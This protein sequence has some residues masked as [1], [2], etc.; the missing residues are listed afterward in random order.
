M[1]RQG[2]RLA[3]RWD[4]RSRS[5]WDDR[6]RSRW[7]APLCSVPEKCV[8]VPVIG[9]SLAARRAPFLWGRWG[10]SELRDFASRSPLGFGA[11]GRV[12]RRRC[13]TLPLAQCAERREADV[14]LCCVCRSGAKQDPV[15]PCSK[16]VRSPCRLSEGK[17]QPLV[18]RCLEPEFVVASSQ[19]WDQG[20]ATTMT[21]AD[22][23]R[24][25]PRNGCNIPP[26]A[27]DQPPIRRSTVGALRLGSCGSWGGRPIA[28]HADSAAKHEPDAAS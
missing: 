4:D 13:R 8:L 16:S 24:F 6:S 11:I 25:G 17:N 5:R 12:A 9:V 14:W 18:W 19:I 20:V 26:V 2:G 21:R 7:E 15:A 3:T 23:S 1:R 28:G 27:V 10:Q 22:P